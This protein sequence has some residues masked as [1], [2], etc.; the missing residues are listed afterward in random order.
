MISN[1][2]FDAAD[3]GVWKEYTFIFSVVSGDA[4]ENFNAKYDDIQFFFNQG[5]QANPTATYY[6]D[7]FS[8]NV[9]MEDLE[10]G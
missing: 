3:E 6:F 5:T 10:V 1:V 2:N 7:G 4:S 9:S 8:R